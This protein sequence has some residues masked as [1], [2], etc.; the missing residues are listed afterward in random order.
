MS[1]NKRVFDTNV[2]VVKYN[3][4]KEV[5]RRAYEGGLEDAYY[6]IPKVICPGPKPQI[7]CCIYKER[8]IIQDR[9][10]LAMGGDRNNPN[11][12]EVIDIACD[13]C[14]AEGVMVTPACRGCMVHA[15]QD[16]CPKGAISI[17]NHH[18]TS[19]LYGKL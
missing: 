4:L 6:E 7:R 12:V 19:S 5:I 3:V 14:P 18:A 15:C 16:V 10:K 9:I 1:T 2:Q 17:V 11:P 8:T 13:E